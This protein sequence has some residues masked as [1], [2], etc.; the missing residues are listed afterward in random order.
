MMEQKGWDTTQEKYFSALQSSRSFAP[1]YN[2]AYT[3]NLSNH[4][5]KRTYPRYRAT[6]QRERNESS[7]G[8]NT[9][10][11]GDVMYE[12]PTRLGHLNKDTEAGH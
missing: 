9:S 10:H 8:G 4:A 12:P 5:C 11:F 1:R 6:Q 2:K 3:A 7:R